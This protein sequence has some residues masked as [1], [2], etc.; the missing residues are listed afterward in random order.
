MSEQ[1]KARVRGNG[2]AS[3]EDLEREMAATRAEMNETLQALGQRLSPEALLQQAMDQFGGPGEF[4]SNLGDAVKRNPL[5]AALAS[6]GV[7]WLMMAHR[8]GWSS[9][10]TSPE[11][12]HTSRM[13]EAR[14][15]GAEAI[16]SGG[17]RLGEAGRGASRTAQQMR[18]RAEEVSARTRAQISKA[19]ESAREWATQARAKGSE[20]GQRA[21]GFYREQPLVVGA[22][23]L[24]VGAL[25]GLAIQKRSEPE[26]LTR[27]REEVTRRAEHTA[28]EA[29]RGGGEVA[30]T[31]GHAA[32][33]KARE[34]S[35]EGDKPHT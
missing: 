34:I 5:P 18:D 21:S 31:A 6:I 12:S 10:S 2:H 17:E 13:E 27:Q 29:L 15:R 16:H 19:S 26:T 3:A 8:Q 7:G 9:R 30:R 32:A 1:T 22:L 23:A 28:S 24:G 35:T 25:V 20:T 11:V 14:H 33:E 4:T